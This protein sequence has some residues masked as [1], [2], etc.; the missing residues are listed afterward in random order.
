MSTDQKNNEEEVDLG[1]LFIIIG[2]GFSKFFNFIGNIFKGIFHGLISILIF[3]KNNI[4]KIGIAA[5]I[6]GILGTFLEVKK[7]D[8]YESELLLEPNFES[9]RQ[10]YDNVSYYNNLV[11]QKDTAG[12]AATFKLDKPAAASLKGF[13]LEP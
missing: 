5:L 12:L 9:T 11:K 7:G 3:L 13:V 6:G 8:Y 1:S 10:L 4:I 2:R